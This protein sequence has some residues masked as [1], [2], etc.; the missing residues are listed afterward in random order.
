MVSTAV[1][2]TFIRFAR[3]QLTTTNIRRI[4]EKAGGEG[5]RKVKQGKVTQ[6]I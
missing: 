1:D 3:N 5:V 2:L 6:E 4:R